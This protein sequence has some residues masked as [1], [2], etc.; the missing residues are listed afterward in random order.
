[1]NTITLLQY[2][3]N[4]MRVS[5]FTISL[6]EEMEVSLA[7]INFKETSLSS[8]FQVIIRYHFELYFQ[9]KNLCK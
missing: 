2:N 1:M 5:E 8:K 3:A 6:Y 4:R 9:I 7:E